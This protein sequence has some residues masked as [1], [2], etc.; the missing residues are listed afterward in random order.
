MSIDVL[1]FKPSGKLD[2]VEDYTPEDED[3]PIDLI[4][5]DIKTHYR[6]TCRGMHLIAIFTDIG[7]SMMQPANE[8]CS[9]R[10]Y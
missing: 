7:N 6:N 10:L 5:D 1:F 2:T 9:C 8:R 3:R 4:F